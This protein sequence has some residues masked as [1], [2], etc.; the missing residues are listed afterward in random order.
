MWEHDPVITKFIPSLHSNHFPKAGIFSVSVPAKNISAHI[1]QL[2]HIHHVF[3][4]SIMTSSTGPLKMSD[5]WALSTGSQSMS[6]AVNACMQVT[7][8]Q[9]DPAVRNTASM[10]T[11]KN[12]VTRYVYVERASD[13]MGE[14]HQ[15]TCIN[16]PCS[17]RVRV[18][19]T[20]EGN[21][22]YINV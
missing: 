12:S 18:Q 17:S 22:S 21:Y 20:S 10:S 5:I 8:F 6:V 7:R 1:Q 11:M 3:N 14:I 2:N 13:K 9:N 16:V 15:S 19:P 4:A